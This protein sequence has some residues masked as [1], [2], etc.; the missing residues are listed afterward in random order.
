MAVNT[1]R[2]SVDAARLPEKHTP[3]RWAVLKDSDTVMMQSFVAYGLPMT[4]L[5]DPTGKVVARA[6]GPADWDNPEAVAYF[7][8]ITRQLMLTC[9]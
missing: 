4:V 6:D 9:R 7:K 3:R 1:D 2:G 5:I 8:R